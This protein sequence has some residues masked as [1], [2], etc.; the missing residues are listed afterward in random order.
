MNKFMITAVLLF[1]SFAAHAK[2]PYEGTDEWRAVCYLI[3]GYHI[4]C[5]GVAQ[6][7]VKPIQAKYLDKGSYGTS[8]KGVIYYNFDKRGEPKQVLGVIV[9]EMTHYL[10]E[11]KGM[12]LA[13]DPEHGKDWSEVCPSESYAF[14]VENS[15]YK[16]MKWDDL[17]VPQWW[18]I[19]GYRCSSKYR[20]PLN[21]K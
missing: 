16:L 12:Y 17:I 7:P 13:H 11:Q 4:S 20:D 8:Y 15:F 9:H 18:K 2:N 6:P 1:V 21:L 19:K 3:S 14:A 5:D 10:L